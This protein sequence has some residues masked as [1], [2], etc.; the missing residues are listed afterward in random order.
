MTKYIVKD[1]FLYPILVLLFI[2]VLNLKKS[3]DWGFI[4]IFILISLIILCIIFYLKSDYY[5]QDI[6]IEND[7]L[8]IQYQRNFAKDKVNTV[9]IDSKSLKSFKFNSNS[10]P[11]SSHLITIR[12]NDDEDL[13]YKKT[14]K[15]N[16]DDTFIKLIN[17]LRRIKN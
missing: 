6:S 16:C 7:I 10:S 8:R 2:G 1:K 12:Y 17:E 15:T 3:N 9:S 11:N 14:F 5:I 4:L 13:H